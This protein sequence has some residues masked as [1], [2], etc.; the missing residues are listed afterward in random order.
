[1]PTVNGQA[2]QHALIDVRVAGTAGEFQFLT[3]KSIEFKIGADKEAV[4]D[5]QGQQIGY[6]IKPMK[7]T[8][9]LSCN[10]DEWFPFYDWLQ[11]QASALAAQLQKPIGPLQVEF[12]VTVTFGA[13][14]AKLKTR[15]LK[16]C[17]INEEAF[18]SKDDQNV[19]VQEIPLFVSRIEDEN[20]R[21]MI[22]YRKK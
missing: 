8:A 16:S 22:E 18:S 6:T 9:K 5:A 11:Q 17:L 12:D 4:Y 15:R 3:F 7:T 13:V 21:S 2:L 19:L 10:T 1:M 20:G 14:L